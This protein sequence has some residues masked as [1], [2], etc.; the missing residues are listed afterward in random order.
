MTRRV[1]PCRNFVRYPVAIFIFI[2][3]LV[4]NVYGLSPNSNNNDGDGSGERNGEETTTR[5]AKTAVVTLLTT[6]NY[7]AGAEVLALS[8][9]RVNATGDRI[10]LWVSPD[11]DARSDLTPQDLQDLKVAGWDT[12]IQLTAKDGTLSTCKVTPQMEEQMRS[13]PVL[14][15]MTRYWGTC[16]KFAIWTLTEYDAVVYMDADSIALHN[17]DFVYD[18]ILNGSA[19]FAAQGTPGCWEDPPDCGEFYSAFM[20]IK[21]MPN[22]NEYLHGLSENTANPGGDIFVLNEVIKAWK[23]LPR[24][25]L[26]AQSETARP[27]LYPHDPDARAVDWEQ[28]KVYDFAGPAFNKPWLTYDLQKQTG[29]KYSHPHFQKVIPDSM[30]YHTYMQPQYFWNEHYDEVLKLKHQKKND[31]L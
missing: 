28:V 14:D 20:V 5:K 23:P 12:Q 30:A 3:L 8:L 18:D 26:V 16:S 29:D 25:T 11:D 21:P 27:M 24:Y 22:I 31:E 7:V 2:L 17:F 10:L 1:Y 13:D 6:Q 9:K 15:G 19:V 4:R